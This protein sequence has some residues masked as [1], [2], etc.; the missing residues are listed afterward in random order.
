[1]WKSSRKILEEY[2][3]GNKKLKT[4]SIDKV[5]LEIENIYNNYKNQ[6]F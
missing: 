6:Q 2:I 3:E 1:M 4:D 5:V